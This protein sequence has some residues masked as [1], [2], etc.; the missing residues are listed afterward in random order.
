MTATASQTEA[1][2]ANLPYLRRYGRALTGSQISGDRFAAVTLEALLEDLSPMTAAEDPRV[3]LFRCF[4]LIWTSAGAPSGDADSRLSHS[5]QAHM[6]NLTPR[7]REALLLNVI[8]G[9]TQEQVARVLDTSAAEVSG[10]IA[11]AFREMEAAV[12]GRVLVIEDEVIIAMDIADIVESIGHSV[13]G[14]AR[15]RAQA[16]SLADRDPPDLI[17]A[18]IQLADASS[19]I[20][21]V[22]DILKEFPDTPA[23]F[24]T[25]F[26]ERLLTGDRPE[27]AFLITKPFAEDQ[28]RTAVSQA[29]FFGSTETLAS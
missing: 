1:I 27:P 6:R 3:A 29:M 16:V 25:S 10:L 20:D 21:A 26:P 5:A 4:H 17:L 13:T 12:S 22:A 9:F 18:D 28:V 7:S 8:E 15:T 23:I 19:G 14:I 2:A 11:A 24:I